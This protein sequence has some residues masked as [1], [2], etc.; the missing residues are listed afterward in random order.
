MTVLPSLFSNK[1]PGVPIH[2]KAGNINAAL[3]F[4]IF[5][6]KPPRDNDIVIIF[7]ADMKAHPNFL[8]HVLPYLEEDPQTALVQTPQHFFNV[9][10]TG[11]VFNHQNS[12]FF[13]GVQVKLPASPST[14]FLRS[15]VRSIVWSVS[16]ITLQC[17]LPPHANSF[18]E[19]S[20]CTAVH[21]LPST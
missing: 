7:D 21:C 17:A 15:C 18:L 9:D 11:D 4:F 13:F 6:K 8:Q 3:K 5:A 14:R 10:H 1:W 12:T 16:P 2:G 20:P 19:L